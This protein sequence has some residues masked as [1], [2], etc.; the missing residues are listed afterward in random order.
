VIDHTTALYCITA[1]LLKVAGHKDDVRCELTD[2]EVITTA[3]IAALYFGGN[4]ERHRSFMR[5]TGLM[6][7]MLSKSRLTR[8]LYLVAGPV[9]QPLPSTRRGLERGEHLDQVPVGLVLRRGL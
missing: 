5:S 9:K 7:Q 3:L 6:P 8:R 4:I 1:D 2:A